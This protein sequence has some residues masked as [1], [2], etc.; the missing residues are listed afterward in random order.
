VKFKWIQEHR[1]QFPAAVMCRVLQVSGSGFYAW[2]NRPTSP[3]RRRREQLARQIRAVHGQ[4]RGVYGSPRVH[5]TLVA[6]GERV[7]ENTVAKIM[8]QEQ[9][10]ARIRRKFW[11]RTTDSRH[12]HATAENRLDRDF[13]AEAPDRKWVADITYV[14]TAQGFLYLAAV[15]DLYSRKI[16]GWSMADHLRAELVGDALGMAL[17]RRSPA[18]GLLHHSDRGV[19]YACDDYQALLAANR[20][21]CSMSRKGNCWDNAAMESFFA[22]LKSELVNDAAYADREQARGSIFEY[23]EVFYNRKRLHSSLGY[24]SPEAFEASLN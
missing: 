22:T 12:A 13:A 11:P 15:M 9:V 4:N 10:R 3:R 16:V 17:A 14:P 2:Q 6:R 21:E 8:R 5:R 1:G 19:Q 20:I 7:C 23:I 24:L 18:A